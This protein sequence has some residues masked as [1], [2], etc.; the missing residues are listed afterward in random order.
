MVGAGFSRNSIPIH[1]H[2][3][4]LPDWNKLGDIFYKKL[5]GKSPGVDSRYLNLLKLAEQVESTFGRFTLDDL[6]KNEI[7]DLSYNPS[8]LHNKLLEL[9]WR[10]VFTTNYDTLLER[11]PLSITLG[12][13][14]LVN[15]KVDLLHAKA[16][17]IVKL[18]GSL[19]SPPYVITEE[20]YRRYPID[21]APFVNTVCQSLIENT[22]CLIGFSGDD[23]NFLQWI[24]WIRDNFKS[25]STIKIFLLGVH[26]NLTSS[27]R[28]LLI[29]RDINV[30]DLNN[31]D[32]T[33]EKSIEDFFKYLK[34]KKPTT[35]FWDVQS[36]E[37]TELEN[38]STK[39][40]PNLV[41][42]WKKQ[43]KN[44]PGWV[45]IPTNIRNKFYFDNEKFFNHFS[46]GKFTSNNPEL[47]EDLHIELLYELG[48]RL[49]K[50][51]FPLEGE[52]PKIFETLI[53]TQKEKKISKS[54]ISNNLQN[55]ILEIQFWLLRYYREKG[56]QNNWYDIEELV[57]EDFD[58][59]SPEYRTKFQLE[60]ALQAIF[61]FEP[62][63]ARQI[64]TS[65]EYTNSPP[66]LEAKRAALLAE[67]GEINIAITLLEKALNSIRELK[68]IQND[69]TFI[70]QESI[71]LMILRAVNR[72]RDFENNIFDE[73]K[74][75]EISERQ[76]ELAKYNCDPNR[77]LNEFSEKFH[78]SKEYISEESSKTFDLVTNYSYKL[79]RDIR[80][81]AVYG[82][83]RIRE[84]I[85]LP[86]RINTSSYDKVDIT[87]KLPSL[88][89]KWPHWAL[90]NMIRLGQSKETDSVFD[91]EYLAKLS[92][93]EV[94]QIIEN[95]LPSITRMLSLIEEYDHQQ[96]Q[97][98]DALA[99]T[100]PELLSRLSC[101]CSPE[102][103]KK[104]LEIL[105]SIYSSKHIRMFEKVENLAIRLIQSMS[106]V[107]KIEALPKLIEFPIPNTN[108]S[109][110]LPNP[111]DM[112]YFPDQIEIK[113]IPR[114]S[115]NKLIS[116]FNSE[117]YHKKW[118]IKSLVWLYQYQ[119]LNIKQRNFLAKILWEDC[120]ERGIP[121]GYN[122]LTITELHPNT[123]D[124]KLRVKEYVKS[125]ITNDKQI[126]NKNDL[127]LLIHHSK[128][129]GWTIDEAFEI[130]YV[131]KQNIVPILKPSL[132]R[133]FYVDL[134]TALRSLSA[135]FENLDKSKFNEV[136]KE[137]LKRL[138]GFLNDNN[139][140]FLMFKS[141]TLEQNSKERE[142][143]VNELIFALQ[144]SHEEITE[145]AII[146]IYN[147]LKNTNFQHEQELPKLL[148]ILSDGIRWRHLP[149]LAR[150]LE[151]ANILVKEK[152]KFLSQEILNDFY[153]GLEEIDIETKQEIKGHDE[154]GKIIIRMGAASLAN[155]LYKHNEKN[156]T[157]EFV[158]PKVLLKWKSIC[159]DPNEFSEV[160]NSWID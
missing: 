54:Y 81:D 16:P 64:L 113:K 26:K 131:I 27:E 107:E 105:Q 153:A 93:N 89:T 57:N 24:G 53:I 48:W 41:K 11:V 97:K 95:Y 40:Y 148:K 7:S 25:D 98:F 136:H 151:V 1:N 32:S 144:S 2:K 18:H 159:Q 84:E 157:S 63:R 42:E 141:A 6:L 28:S 86:F 36:Q 68:P 19:P 116:Q 31:S 46:S 22:L 125:R 114:K 108:E 78:N 152:N 77:T 142:E 156:N 70:S 128:Y 9:P 150:R 124:P 91:R 74:Y 3:H 109:K 115:I 55:K 38:L 90:V 88:A 59:L 49:E 138:Y 122:F 126:V 30:V 75:L 21:N 118:V 146:T 50:L 73:E 112:V 133:I 143:F 60:R 34:E 158:Q 132:I 87:A 145:D 67:L 130:A 51:M 20:D 33:P 123:I 8:N 121:E 4:N 79:G 13:Y 106:Y 92:R 120:L 101:K 12:R 129:F 140:S 110:P 149:A 23:P 29:K 66:F 80:S 100:S 82:Y 39:D 76:S 17:R 61:C 85:S 5:Y 102:Y 117:K 43:R 134:P 58:N 47:S 15:K 94:D 71:V 160:R 65:N 127:S 10:D 72:V 83:F 139:I 99:K 37:L 52:I 69:Y 137:K 155:S 103:R 104:F 135:I 35:I 147:I 111:L 56:L 96:A 62:D 45:I 14:E 154:D 119:M 44:Y